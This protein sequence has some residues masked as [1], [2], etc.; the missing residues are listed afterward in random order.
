MMPRQLRPASLKRTL[1]AV[2][3]SSVTKRIK[4]AAVEDI[5]SNRAWVSQTI[6]YK[7]R[8]PQT[9]KTLPRLMPLEN[10]C[11]PEAIKMAEY[12]MPRNEP[13]SVAIISLSVSVRNTKAKT[14]MKHIA[15]T[16][17]SNEV[18][19][20]QDHCSS[21]G[22]SSGALGVFSN[23]VGVDEEEIFTC[24]EF[25]KDDIFFSSSL[26]FVLRFDSSVVRISRRCSMFFS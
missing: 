26:V 11:Q 4:Y 7:R 18:D 2:R 21:P 8:A 6:L 3:D 5:D 19:A 22:I 16:C 9:G 14:K 1:V 10:I 12:A 20:T 15:A 23:V 17:G 13:V 24:S 25:V